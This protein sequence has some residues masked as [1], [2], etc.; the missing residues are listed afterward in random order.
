MPL[1]LRIDL[2]SQ[3]DGWVYNIMHNR[4]HKEQ[5]EEAVIARLRYSL[6]QRETLSFMSKNNHSQY[7]CFI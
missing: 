3:Y 2:V 7:L 4:A 6:P 1:V 5:K